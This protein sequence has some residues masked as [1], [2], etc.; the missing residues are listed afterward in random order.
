MRR[1]KKDRVKGPIIESDKPGSD[2]DD[3]DQERGG[4]RGGKEPWY[5]ADSGG[6]DV[7]VIGGDRG[8]Y[9]I[10]K[11]VGLYLVSPCISHCSP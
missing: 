11:F 7:H 5:E 3:N 2:G 6:P 1:R 8:A 10:S 4:C 9:A